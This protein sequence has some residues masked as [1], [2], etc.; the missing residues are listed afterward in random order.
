MPRETP[1]MAQ[2]TRI[3][4]YLSLTTW[5]RAR[6]SR[7][8]VLIVRTGGQPAPYARIEAAAWQRYMA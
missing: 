2:T 5:A 8:G 7:N 4:R 1:A 6:Y 3:L